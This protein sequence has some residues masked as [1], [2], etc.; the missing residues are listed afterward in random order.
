MNEKEMELQQSNTLSDEDT[1][2]Y[3][4]TAL[5]AGT[6]ALGSGA[7]TARSN[8]IVQKILESSGSKDYVSTVISK[9]I[10]ASLNGKTEMARVAN[11]STNLNKISASNEISKKI[12]SVLFSFAATSRRISQSLRPSGFFGE[13]ESSSPT[14]S[15]SSLKIWLRSMFLKYLE[16]SD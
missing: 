4:R 9:S 1:E 16:K 10:L 2:E 3:L 6:L 12:E 8:T 15:A 14:K 13:A 11:W 5:K 7:E